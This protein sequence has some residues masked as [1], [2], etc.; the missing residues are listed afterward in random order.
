MNDQH[1]GSVHLELLLG[2]ID[3]HDFG[4]PRRKLLHDRRASPTQHHGSQLLPELAQV[5][6]AEHLASFRYDSVR[7]VKLK[8]RPELAL[9]HELDHREQ[10][11][12]A[13]LERRAGERER[14]TGAQPLDDLRGLRL[15]VLD[16]LRLV[17]ND[18]IPRHLFDGEDVSEY[19]LVVAHR[20]ER[21]F[22]AVLL[23]SRGSR[24]RHKV[25][26]PRT[27]SFDLGLP[28]PFH[29]GGTNDEHL[30]DA[31]LSREE[32]ATPTP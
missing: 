10:I 8:R 5:L 20:V 19:L 30:R 26:G 25:R 3:S 21:I 22:R 6:V 18:Q 16:P 24:S 15:P 11:V 4:R 31:D 29:R 13:I 27:E 14:E 23:G 17:E 9:V 12:E 7:V 32:L 2:R 28:L 1:P